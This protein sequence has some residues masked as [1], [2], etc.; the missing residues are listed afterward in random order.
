LAPSVVFAAS[1]QANGVPTE[2]Y[3]P[4]TLG[5]DQMPVKG[6]GWGPNATLLTGLSGPHQFYL[7]QFM[8]FRS[9]GINVRARCLYQTIDLSP[10]AVQEPWVLRGLEQFPD[11]AFPIVGQGAAAATYTG[12]DYGGAV[13]LHIWCVDVAGIPDSNCSAPI[14]FEPLDS[15]PSSNSLKDLVQQTILG[16]AGIVR[17]PIGMHLPAV[18]GVSN[19]F[20]VQTAAERYDVGDRIIV[21]V[22]PG[23]LYKPDPGF[24][25]WDN[26]EIIYYALAEITEIEPNT[27]WAK[28]VGGPYADPDQIEGY[29]SRIVPWDWEGPA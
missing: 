16:L 2:Y 27:L 10:F 3:E 18:S 22:Y 29:R 9:M 17:P 12:N 4:Y 23:E 20:L 19:N 26:V 25:N 5:A 21:L 28:F 7:A 11:E 6:V 1:L 8:G 13:L 14:F 15:S 24:G